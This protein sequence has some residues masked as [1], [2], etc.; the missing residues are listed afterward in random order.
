MKEG[1]TVDGY[2]GTFGYGSC[3]SATQYTQDGEV[4]NTFGVVENRDG[5]L[6]DFPAVA[7]TCHLFG[8]V[9]HFSIIVAIFSFHIYRHIGIDYGGVF[10]ISATEYREVRVLVVVIRFLPFF[11]VQKIERSHTLQYF[12]H[13]STSHVAGKITATIDVMRV[14]KMLL[15]VFHIAGI[16]IRSGCIVPYNEFIL[17]CIPYLV[18]DDI[19]GETV[20]WL[21]FIAFFLFAEVV[22][23]VYVGIA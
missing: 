8:I 19:D 13:G 22:C 12:Y 3:I 21:S 4:R 5:S 11:C 2:L 6:S 18:P 10:T 15:A 9:I 20:F 16:E 14:Q 23:Q 1:L 17:F 7:G